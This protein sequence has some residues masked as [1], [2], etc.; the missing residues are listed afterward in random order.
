MGLPGTQSRR[1]IPKRGRLENEKLEREILSIPNLLLPV[2]LLNR[3]FRSAC[4]PSR[5]PDTVCASKQNNP[6]RVRSDRRWPIAAGAPLSRSLPSPSERQNLNPGFSEP[7]EMD[8]Q[9]SDGIPLVPAETGH[10]QVSVWLTQPCRALP[11]SSEERK[12]VICNRYPTIGDA[13]NLRG[14]DWRNSIISL[15]FHDYAPP[16]PPVARNL[17]GRL[18]EKAWQRL[19]VALP[20]V[21]GPGRCRYHGQIGRP[22]RK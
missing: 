2:L 19:C 15:V 14:P 16:R 22:R 10:P 21:S 13:T 11:I 1:T 18:S 7:V 20:A 4:E 5:L 12:L 9:P 6:G 17:S 3:P 8:P